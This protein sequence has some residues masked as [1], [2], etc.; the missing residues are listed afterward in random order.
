M[1]IENSSVRLL[2]L[3][4][5]IEQQTKEESLKTWVGSRRPAFADEKPVNTPFAFVNNPP[6]GDTLE[7][8][9]EGKAALEKQM[10]ASSTGGVLKEGEDDLELSD[11]DKQKLYMLQKMIESLTGKKLNFIVP[12]KIKL[13]HPQDNIQALPPGG[14]IPPAQIQEKRQGWGIEYDLHETHYEKQTM[15]FSAEGTV[16]TADGKEINFDLNLNMSREFA[17]RMDVSFRA[18]DAV[19]VDPLVINYGSPAATLTNN[20][21]SFDIDNDGDSE[22]V[23]FATGGSGFLAFD[24]NNDGRINDG[25]ELFGPQSG[26]GFN[27]LA[28]YDG[29][30]NGWIDEN[31]E[32]Y[33]KL[34]IWSKDESGNDQL[35]AI[36]EKGIGAIYLGNAAT[37]YDKKDSRNQTL[38][39]IASTGIFLNENG[40]AGTIQHVDL[41][42]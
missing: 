17:S 9:P 5:S 28:R 34:R 32:I 23:S 38:G 4:T 7:L 12:K 20:K 27:D 33:N 18:G 13:Q 21:F 30:S 8:S 6:P 14:N 11:K 39:S 22:Q 1:R 19:K 37:A 35:F 3:S 26:N 25:S 36:G 31:D 10:A 42:V 29:D 24:M 41:V 16:K 15:S 2:G 40:S